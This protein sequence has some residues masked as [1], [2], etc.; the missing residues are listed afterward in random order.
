MPLIEAGSAIGLL[1]MV[2]AGSVELLVPSPVP[3][4]FHSTFMSPPAA[5]LK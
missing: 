5:I 4:F 2:L 3:A 1:A